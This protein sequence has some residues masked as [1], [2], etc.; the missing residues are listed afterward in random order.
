VKE[1]AE[2]ERW[3]RL[4]AAFDELVALA[5]DERGVR[6][7]E[8]CGDELALRRELED[9]LSAADAQGPLDRPAD[10]ALAELLEEVAAPDGLEVIGRRIG[11]YRVLEEIGRGGMGVV[12]LAERADGEFEQRVAIKLIKRGLDTDELLARFRRERQLLA[13]LDHRAIARVLDGGATESGRPYF[14]MEHV[15][16][17]PITAYCDRHR[18]SIE[19]RLLLFRRVCEAVHH[20]HRRLVVHR[21]LKPA[22]ILVTEE[23]DLKLLDFGLAKLLAADDEEPDRQILTRAGRHMLTPQYAAPEQVT[24]EPVSTATDVY[25]LGIVLYALLTGRQAYRLGSRFSADDR[26]TILE[27]EPP[28]PSAVAEAST[29]DGPSAGELARLRRSSP[30]ALRRRLSGDLDAI[31]LTA[32]RKEPERRYGSAQAFAE[33]IQ[34]HL[35]GQPVT[36]RPERRR[37]RA[38]KF[39]RRH[40]VGV[41]TVLGVFA[42][43]VIELATTAWQARAARRQATR[44]EQVKQFLVNV[45]EGS[46]PGPESGP[47]T[48]ARELLDRG[49]ARIREELVD[50][51]DLRAEMLTLL[52]RIYDELTL[53]D[54][55]L[56]LADEAVAVGRRLGGGATRE[57][58]DALETKASL[59][60]SKER[61]DEA[62]EALREVIPMRRRL[63]G[64]DHSDVARAQRLLGQTLHYQAAYD[65]ALAQ[66]AEALALQRRVLGDRHPEVATTLVR[67]GRTARESGDSEG[68]ER[69]YREAL[70]IRRETL[71]PDHPDTTAP[72]NN[73]A[74]VLRDRG[75]L[76]EAEALFREALASDL[77]HR[78]RQHLETSTTM[79]NLATVLREQ[80]RYAEAEA[81][82]REVVRIDR[83]LVGDEHRFVPQG[84]GNLA[85]ILFAKGE[86]EEAEALQR[87]AVDL[88]RRLLGDD[89]PLTADGDRQLAD[90]LAARGALVE[91]ETLYRRAVAA[92][93]ARFPGGHRQLGEAFIGLGELLAASGRDED[94]EK[95][96]GR[97]VEMLARLYPSEPWRA[98]RAEAALASWLTS[99][100]RTEE[101]EPLLRR[102]VES[103]ARRFGLQSWQVAEVQTRLA[104]CLASR[105]RV[106]EARRLLTRAVE[107]LSTQRGPD[108]PLS[109]AAR[110]LA[111]R[112]EGAEPR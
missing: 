24:G 50:Q 112:L 100:G 52:A 98:G 105:G 71:G 66:Y 20:A 38:Q 14:A 10:E 92:F 7:G 87:E 28:R 32:L 94:A 97:A 75:A 3:R 103:M 62:E 33:D 79:N 78:G 88:F 9:L 95:L 21:D 74:L 2:S 4:A 68:A 48:T 90:M 99:R 37:Y 27:V 106:D 56:E 86:V 70:E 54:S 40:R 53:F 59:L 85:E 93:E 61:P 89:H 36:A 8:I 76:A 17:L 23:G 58:A 104:E 110:D 39:V 34:R 25:S 72:M 69:A 43:L 11:P 45:F 60:L 65:E 67:V 57:L 13:R 46:D 83:S 82:Q 101:A 81:F 109:R 16:G 91:A 44:A 84:L 64:E 96:F 63:L 22:N 102:A 1:P 5:P 55:G 18:L 41:A 31:T 73:L 19:A 15:T 77:R 30:R 80:A 35:A 107:T 47:Q 29:E 111:A 108:H 12:Y 51:P 26:R 6:L 49:A 42:M